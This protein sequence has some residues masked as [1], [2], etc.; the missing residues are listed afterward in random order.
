M[1]VTAREALNGPEQSTPQNLKTLDSSKKTQAVVP[2]MLSGLEGESAPHGLP[3]TSVANAGEALPSAL[4]SFHGILEPVSLAV[5]GARLAGAV[6]ADGNRLGEHVLDASAG[7]AGGLLGS[8]LGNAVGVPTGEVIGAGIGALAGG[9]LGAIA[10][11]SA[12]G[13][14]GSLLGSISGGIAG[15]HLGEKTVDAFH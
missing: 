6:H 8:L 7:I 14:L 13:L 11:A 2:P 3:A 10:G 12:G 15:A 9:P 5:D 4:K 1:H